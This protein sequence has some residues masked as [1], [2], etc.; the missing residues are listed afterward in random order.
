MEQKSNITIQATIAQDSVSVSEVPKTHYDKDEF[1]K[2]QTCSS[3][4]LKSFNL[5]SFG[6]PKSKGHAYCPSITH[7][8][9]NDSA[10]MKSFSIWESTYQEPVEKYYEFMINAIDFILGWSQETYILA[11]DYIETKNHN[12]ILTENKS[13]SARLLNDPLRNT[14]TPDPEITTNPD[15]QNETE[16]DH[17]VHNSENSTD[18][19]IEKTEDPDKDH[20]ISREHPIIPEPENYS[21]EVEPENEYTEERCLKAAKELQIIPHN[22]KIMRNHSKRS[23]MYYNDLAQLRSGF[24]CLLCDAE[25]NSLHSFNWESQSTEKSFIF[26]QQFCSQFIEKNFLHIEFMNESFKKYVNNAITL[27]ECRKKSLGEESN[28]KAPVV[29]FEYT[30]DEDEAYKKCKEGRLSN[31]K[32]LFSCEELC[33]FFDLT[34]INTFIDGN[35]AQINKVINYFNANKVYF[36]YPEN[37]FLIENPEYTMVLLNDSYIK[38]YNQRNFFYTADS[39]DSLDISNTQIIQADGPDI[40]KIIEGN[41]YPLLIENEIIMAFSMICVFFALIL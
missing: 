35:V 31:D 12:R 22:I 14:E 38:S 23:S 8:C 21:S 18:T 29:T 1:E 5:E 32:S 4:L 28:V 26:G 15:E 25:F 3:N 2:V 13:N 36:Q 6:V 33:G 10:E 20:V 34:T 17:I 27:L 9:C 24:Y 19:D 16:V 37:N 39:D 7:S 41:R 30:S 11:I 40:Y